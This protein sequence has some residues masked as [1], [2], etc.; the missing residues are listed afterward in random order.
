[1][2][3]LLLLGDRR[4]SCSCCVGGGR[5]R[6]RKDYDGRKEHSLYESLSSFMD[7]MLELKVQITQ[8]Q[9]QSVCKVISCNCFLDSTVLRA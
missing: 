1:M 5:D 9:N 4:V 8:L 6:G 7:F 3:C 2:Q